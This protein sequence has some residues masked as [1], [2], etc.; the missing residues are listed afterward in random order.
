MSRR[1][2]LLSVALFACV[3][4]IAVAVPPTTDRAPSH[5]PTRPAAL[6]DPLVQIDAQTATGN[7]LLLGVEFALGYYWVTG[8]DSAGGIGWLYK[9]DPTGAL[10]STYAQAAG[11]TGWGGR[12]LA[13]DGSYLYYGCDDGLIHQTDPA[14][15]AATAVTIPSPLTPARALAYV[16][17]TDHFWTA[18]WDSTIYEIDR[19]GTVI[20]AFSPVGLS[21]YGFAWDG[22]S[23]GGPYL[24]SWSQDGGDPALLASQI[25]PATGALT[26]AS[27]AGTGLSGDM[28]GG[29]GTSIEIPGHLNRVCLVTMNQAGSDTIVVYDLNHVVPVELTA[30]TVE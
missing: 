28:A 22:W 19:T 7:N 15:G 26:G 2:V 24:W 6:G 18:S 30:F 16:A 9:L 10:V 12:D 4:G 29:A 25:N 17:A 13:F 21:T 1:D 27:F 11:C 8:G 14:T 20:H 5:S 3:A 23:P